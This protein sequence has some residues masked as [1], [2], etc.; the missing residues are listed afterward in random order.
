MSPLAQMI[1][2]SGPIGSQQAHEI[3]NAYS[4]AFFDQHLK[5]QLATLLDRLAAQYPEVIF[6]HNR[7]PTISQQVLSEKSAQR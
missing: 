5:G 6:E 1:G 4:L 2:F 3:I 7:I